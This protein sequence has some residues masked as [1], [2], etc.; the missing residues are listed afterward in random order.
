MFRSPVDLLE[1]NTRGDSWKN[2]RSKGSFMRNFETFELN[3]NDYVNYQK[4]LCVAKAKL[5]EI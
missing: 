1:I 5:E 4:L 3:K 2:L